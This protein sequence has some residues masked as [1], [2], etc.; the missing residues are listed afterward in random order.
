ME[1]WGGERKNETGEKKP[2][3]CFPTV[4][5]TMISEKEPGQTSAQNTDRGALT[6]FGMATSGISEANYQI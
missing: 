4:H 3:R 2:F 6:S 5:R 1:G